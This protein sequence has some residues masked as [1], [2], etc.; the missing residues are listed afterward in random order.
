MNIL[1][2]YK[3]ELPPVTYGGT[4]R[5][6]WSLI[7]G[8][9]QLNHNVYLLSPTAVD[10]PWA[11]T[12]LHDLS[13]PLD[14]QIPDHIDVVHFHTSGMSE[15][16][17]YVMTRHGNRDASQSNDANSIFV[18]HKHA[19]NHGCEAFVHNGLDWSEYRTPNLD[20][21][22]RLN[23]YHFLG[24][25]A[26]RV[27]NVQGAIDITKRAQTQLDVLGGFR[28]N[29]KMGFRLT[30]DQ[31]V[32]FHGMVDNEQ[33]CDVLE[34]SRGLVFPVTWEEPFGLAITESLYMGCPVFGTPYGALP[35]LIHSPEF[36]FLSSKE[37]DIV[38]A[39]LQHQIQPKLCH[40]YARDT[41]DHITMA[42]NYV[43]MYERVIAGEALNSFNSQPAE[44]KKG[45]A[46]YR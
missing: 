37:T 19:L 35:E 44:K 1:M 2:V 24:K 5:V 16:K 17:P 38:E 41:F 7:K 10:C 20:P 45:L 13:K 23:R 40:E 11:E 33:K 36:G 6:V 21:S 46:Y 43:M 22:K 8:L 31:H 29:F 3:G 18:S 9:V 30:L 26:W 15:K 28:L 14:E 39:I 42:Q 32:R 27:K 25:A 4:E 12:I 34:R